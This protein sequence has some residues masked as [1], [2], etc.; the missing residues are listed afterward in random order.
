MA[1]GRKGAILDM[2]KAVVPQHFQE[3]LVNVLADG[4]HQQL[5]PVHR[6]VGV[7]DPLHVGENL[8]HRGL[9]QHTR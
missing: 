4:M 7:L 2:D 5:T 9:H 3:L 1:N 6:V 8:L